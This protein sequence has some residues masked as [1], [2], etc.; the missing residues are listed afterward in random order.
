MLL[1]FYV[2]LENKRKLAIIN[3]LISRKYDPDPVKKWKAAQKLDEVKFVFEIHVIARI[4]FRDTHLF[5]IVISLLSI[6]FGKK[7]V[8]GTK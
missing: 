1:C 6:K 7:S 3:E 8:S 5:A 2:M 4:G